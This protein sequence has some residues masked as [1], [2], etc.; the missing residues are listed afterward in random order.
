MTEWEKMQSGESYNSGDATL[1]DLWHTARDLTRDYN[2]LDSRDEDGK[3]R[4][5]AQLLGGRGERLWITPPFFVDYGKNIFIGDNSEINMNC[6]FLDTARIEIGAYALIAPGV[7]I[8][9][10][11]HPTN[12]SERFVESKGTDGFLFSETLTA[13][14]K[15]GD[16]VWI[17]GGAIIMPGVTI[18]NNVVIGA[19]SVVT[20][21]IPSNTIAYGNPCRAVREN[22]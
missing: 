1:L 19:G 14:V 13:P 12:A 3:T 4:I 9:T 11:Y 17:G 7:Q 18:G 21:D 6:T 5:L 16:H 8:Y 2:Q 20:K 10:A 15:I 22:Q